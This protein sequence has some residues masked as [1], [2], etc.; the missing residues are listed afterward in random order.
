MG[1][2]RLNPSVP[3]LCGCVQGAPSRRALSV[4]SRDSCEPSALRGMSM[5]GAMQVLMR[6]FT[7]HARAR[8]VL[9]VVA[10][11]AAGTSAAHTPTWAL[12]AARVGQ[13]EEQVP[14]SGVAPRQRDDALSRGSELFVTICFI[15]SRN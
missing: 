5:K 3:A 14:T 2:L 12:C 13:R 4:R 15:R 8:A 10:A 7:E 9:S 6:I 11:P 1:S